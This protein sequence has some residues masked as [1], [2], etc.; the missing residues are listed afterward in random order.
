MLF[1]VLQVE[2]IIVCGHYGCG[3]VGAAMKNQEN[4]LIDNWLRHLKR[5]LHQICRR[6]RQYCSMKM[7][8]SKRFCELNVIE[9]VHHVLPDNHCPECLEK[10]ARIT[11]TRLDFTG[12][13]MASSTIYWLTLTRREKLDSQFIRYKM[14]KIKQDGSVP[15]CL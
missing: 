5:H 14:Y 12:F 13:T 1:E 10:R 8:V 3:G 11:R 15:S 7:P 6:I 9:Q 4:G 2:H